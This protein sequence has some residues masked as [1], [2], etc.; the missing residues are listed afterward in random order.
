MSMSTARTVLISGAS[1]GLGRATAQ[2]LVR[3]GANVLVHARTKERAAAVAHELAGVPVWADL[4]SA[5]GVRG[6][7]IRCSPTPSSLNR[8]S[9]G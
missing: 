4:G 5:D 9:T 6:L 2:A 1:S 7:G 8:C 3:I